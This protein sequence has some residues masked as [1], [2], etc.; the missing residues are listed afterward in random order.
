MKKTFSILPLIAALFVVS[1]CATTDSSNTKS[2][3]K[4]VDVTTVKILHER[5]ALYRLAFRRLVSDF[6]VMA[7]S[8]VPG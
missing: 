4:M 6:K 5:E 8:E 2:K 1:A 3:Y 7:I